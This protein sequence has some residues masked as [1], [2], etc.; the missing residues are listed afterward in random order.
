MIDLLDCGFVLGSKEYAAD[1]LQNL[2]AKNESL[3][4]SVVSKRGVR[5]L[6]A[7][8]DGPLPQESAVGA[9]RN[10]SNSVVVDNLVSMGILRR[11]VDRE[12][13]RASSRDKGQHLSFSAPN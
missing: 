3:R 12:N 4:R 1:C 7:Y 9:L 5:S 13:G 2:A 8:L 11:L 6:L 10:L